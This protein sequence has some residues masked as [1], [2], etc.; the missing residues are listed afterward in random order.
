MLL[1]IIE[2]PDNT[3]KSTLT[4]ELV[5]YYTLNNKKVLSFHFRAPKGATNEECAHK[6]YE[7]DIQT[8]KNLKKLQSDGH[9][10]VVILDRSWYSE[11]VYGQIYRNRT[12]DDILANDIRDSED[13][14]INN[15]DETVF[16]LTT[17]SKPEHLIKHEDG[18][19]LSAAK[20]NTEDLIKRE[21]ELF[22]EL[23]YNVSLDKKM[24][25][26]VFDENGEFRKRPELFW[27]I[28]KLTKLTICPDN[29]PTCT[30]EEL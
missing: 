5:K 24:F 16:V 21:L 8:A 9:T 23:Y 3:G 13:I 25:L 6:I 28:I 22:K 27:E 17:A 26:P 20:S 14:I 18:K 19:S 7:F 29:C 11:Y 15:I 30:T 4:N 2:G 10:D 12:A 1:I